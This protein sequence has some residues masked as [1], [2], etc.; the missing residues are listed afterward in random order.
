MIEST[1]LSFWIKTLQ[2][3]QS[4]FNGICIAYLEQVFYCLC[5]RIVESEHSCGA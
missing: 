3:H 5:Y 1:S 2:V 4:M